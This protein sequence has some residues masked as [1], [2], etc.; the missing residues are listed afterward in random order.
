MAYKRG[1]LSARTR[2][3][4]R[5]GGYFFEVIVGSEDREGTKEPTEYAY[6]YNPV[7]LKI[8]RPGDRRPTW[9]SLSG[10]TSEELEGMRKVINIGIDDALMV[11]RELDLKAIDLLHEGATEVPFRALASA[12]PYFE[13]ELSVVYEAPVVEDDPSAFIDAD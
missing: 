9:V 12:P 3:Y 1:H 10:M 4:V 13:R 6:G 2:A 5:V 8:G 11:A 7:W